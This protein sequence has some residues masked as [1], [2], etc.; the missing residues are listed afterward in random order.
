MDGVERAAAAW[1]D[2][3]EALGHSDDWEQRFE[4]LAHEG[5]ASMDEFDALLEEVELNGV[6]ASQT[7]R[8]LVDTETQDLADMLEPDPVEEGFFQFEALLTDALDSQRTTLLERGPSEPPRMP[9][10]GAPSEPHVAFPPSEAPE[11]AVF[12]VPPLSE[13]PLLPKPTVQLVMDPDETRYD[14]GDFD[15]DDPAS[16]DFHTKV[17]T[18]ESIMEALKKVA[19][20]YGASQDSPLGQSLRPVEPEAR[21]SEEIIMTLDDEVEIENLTDVD[22]DTQAASWSTEHTEADALSPDQGEVPSAD[23]E[24]ESDGKPGFFKRLFKSNS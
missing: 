24:P 19:M 17:A 10:S 13:A 16:D 12:E 5:R 9:P 8:P 1:D 18:S 3:L 14:A 20:E 6:R 7:E 11:P 2:A 4:R 15:F 21:D 22:V 23:D